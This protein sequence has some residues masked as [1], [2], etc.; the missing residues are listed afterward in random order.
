MFQAIQTHLAAHV[1]ALST[2]N[3]TLL[4]VL[5]AKDVLILF[6]IAAVAIII[7]RV[8]RLRQTARLEE[9]DFRALRAAL[10]KR[11]VDAVRAGARAGN[12]P[13]AAA[14]QAGLDHGSADEEIMREAIAQEVVVQT[15]LL[16]RNLPFL[17]T[18]ASTAP[19]VGLFGTVL[20]ILDAFHTISMTGRTGASVVAGGISEA[21]TATAL[22]LGVAIPAVIAYNYFNG[23]VN[24]LSLMIETHSLDLASRLPELKAADPAGRFGDEESGGEDDAT[25]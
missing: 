16:Q 5:L 14:L 12:A 4:G 9:S 7:E 6:S 8:L 24:R 1:A 13:C 3:L 11:Q 19:Y 15:S 17:G 18:V 10:R 25:R 23:V 22:G 20:G 2:G 21:L